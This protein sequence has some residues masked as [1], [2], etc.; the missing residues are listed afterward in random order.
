VFLLVMKFSLTTSAGRVRDDE[1]NVSQPE[2]FDL[3]KSVIKK[4]KLL[5]MMKRALPVSKLFPNYFIA[6]KAED[7]HL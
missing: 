4:R 6:C 2:M 5:E 1:L 7:W 3:T